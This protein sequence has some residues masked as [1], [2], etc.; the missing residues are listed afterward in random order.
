MVDE[1]KDDFQGFYD[2]A[3]ASGYRDDLT[4][5]RIEC[6]GNYCPENCRWA[7]PKEQANNLRLNHRVEFGGENHTISEWADIYGLKYHTL[8]ARIVIKHW[9]IEE[10]LT[11]PTN[12][13]KQ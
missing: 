9:G 6:D 10:A 3:I 2:W 12:R 5:D 13:R 8:Y 7:T 1:W 4:I 11:T